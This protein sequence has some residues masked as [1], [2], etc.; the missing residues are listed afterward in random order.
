MWYLLLLGVDHKSYSSHLHQ[1]ILAGS[2]RTQAISIKDRTWP[3]TFFHKLSGPLKSQLLSC[4][5]APTK[6]LMQACTSSGN[7]AVWTFPNCP[8]STWN[9]NVVKFK[10]QA[11]QPR[12]FGKIMVSQ[13]FHVFQC[14]VSKYFED[15]PQHCTCWNILCYVS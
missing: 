6:S 1:K 7:K 2:C 3:F 4:Q 10:F 11:L 13:S 9:A 5:Y 8:I 15:D 14:S 12:T